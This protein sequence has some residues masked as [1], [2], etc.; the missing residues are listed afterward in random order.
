MSNNK[1][2]LFVNLLT[3]NFNIAYTISKSTGSNFIRARRLKEEIFLKEYKRIPES[4]FEN[5]EVDSEKFNLLKLISLRS[6]N[7]TFF[8]KTIRNKINIDDYFHYRSARNDNL[9]AIEEKINFLVNPSSPNE[10]TILFNF[11]KNRK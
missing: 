1:K 8:D 6:L 10:K 11:S 5:S 4:L 9:K 2:N 7:E 3:H